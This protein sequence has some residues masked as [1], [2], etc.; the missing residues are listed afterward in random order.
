MLG[1]SPNLYQQATKP[2]TP[3]C[4]VLFLMPA[5]RFS[6]ALTLLSGFDRASAEAGSMV[7]KLLGGAQ[8]L[9]LCWAIGIRR[10]AARTGSAL[11][12]EWITIALRTRL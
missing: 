7:S 6:P 3:V 12:F 4:R 10:T 2:F 9:L 8:T 5:H 1:S 11:T